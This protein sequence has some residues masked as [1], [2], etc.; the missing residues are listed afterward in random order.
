M[1]S[2]C[3]L[4]AAS[5]NV[6][7]LRSNLEANGIWEVQVAPTLGEGLHLAQRLAPQTILVDGDQPETPTLLRSFQEHGVGY[8]V[9]IFLLTSSGVTPSPEGLAGVIPRPA[10]GTL[11]A[12]QLLD[13][14]EEI[15]LARALTRLGKLGGG[16]FTEKM[17]ALFLETAPERLRAAREGLQHGNLRT[18]ALAVH[19]LQSSAGNLGAAITQKLAL[20]IEHLATEGQTATLAPLVQELADS[21]DRF[22]HR[23]HS[24][25]M[26]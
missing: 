22:I 11:L 20:R 4:L 23:L 19:S 12:G 26:G 24:L 8:S 7:N 14:V 9:P 10:R 5:E 18:L 25:E 21:L 3:L 2:Q 6:E 16:T 1:A 15:S 13:R 17:I